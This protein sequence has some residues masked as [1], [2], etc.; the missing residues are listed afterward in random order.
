MCHNGLPQHACV[1]TNV[2]PRYLNNN[3]LA[4]QKPYLY[5]S[6]PL[7]ITTGQIIQIAG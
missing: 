4:P 3:S 6:K 7:R 2:D 5:L 1:L